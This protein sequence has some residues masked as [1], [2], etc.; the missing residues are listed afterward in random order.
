MRKVAAGAQFLVTRPVYDLDSVRRLRDALG[1]PAP[2]LVAVRPLRDFAEA[3]YL[4]NEVP[5]TAVPGVVL[6]VL[7]RAGGRQPRPA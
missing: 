6:D 3:D 5:D 4:A 1:E 2:L 7:A